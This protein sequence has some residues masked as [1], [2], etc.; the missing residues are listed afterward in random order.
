MRT[1]DLIRALSEPELKAIE[2]SLTGAKREALKFAFREIKKYA[3]RSQY[4]THKELF[5]KIMDEPY[6]KDKDYLLRNKMRQINELIYEYL[7]VNTFKKHIDQNPAAYGYWLAKS[8][9][10]R[11]LNDLFESDIDSFLASAKRSV[12]KDESIEPSYSGHLYSLK[13]IWK[14][15]FEVRKPENLRAQAALLGEWQKEEKRRFLYKIREIESRE[16]FLK[17]VIGQQENPNWHIG[18]ATAPTYV[19]DLSEQERGDPFVHYLIMKKK[20]NQHIGWEKVDVLKEM[21]KIG[22]KPE[23]RQMIGP[24]TQITNKILLARELILL[25]DFRQADIYLEEV[26]ASPNVSQSPQ[27]MSAIQNHMSNQ[28]NL[29]NYKRGIKIYE[30]YR[31][32]IKQSNHVRTFDLHLAYLYLFL[33]KEEEALAR[34]PEATKL[35]AQHQIYH[36]YAYL[37]AFIIR[38]ANDLARTDARNIKRRIKRTT[39]ADYKIYIRVLDFFEEYIAALSSAPKE[40]EKKLNALQSKFKLAPDKWND[41]ATDI[42]PL[43]WLMRR[44]EG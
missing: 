24:Y 2:K 44:L 7:A 35:T 19:I 29:G 9:Y 37:I 4:P 18:A 11:R 34:L 15:H 30:Q 23:Y 12:I 28:I 22:Q 20:L 8:Y 6:A 25:G 38:G 41:E 32:E 16:A 10:D 26:L 5:E 42:F 17:A 1:I 21:L 43:R 39:D 3:A 14:I 33:D 40:K 36:R 13:S 27:Y 31:E